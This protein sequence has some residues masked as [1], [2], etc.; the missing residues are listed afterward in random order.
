M[1]LHNQLSC[2]FE[3]WSMQ[4]LSSCLRSPEDCIMV[5]IVSFFQEVW[6]ASSACQIFPT[7]HCFFM[8]T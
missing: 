6:R 4:T 7:G 3:A 5:E 1:V 2:F 8:L